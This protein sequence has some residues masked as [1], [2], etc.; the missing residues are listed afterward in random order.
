[1]RI[2]AICLWIVAIVAAGCVVAYWIQSQRPHEIVVDDYQ[3]A[4]A[5]AR[6]QDKRLLVNFTGYT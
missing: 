4:L 5:S 1:M 2:F 6:A 3:A